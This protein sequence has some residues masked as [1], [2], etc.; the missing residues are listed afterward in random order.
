MQE[1]RGNMKRTGKVDS[2]NK[3]I[4]III[5]VGAIAIMIVNAG[6][7]AE[8]RSVK[9][10]LLLYI[11]A[12]L[13]AMLF[14]IVNDR[15]SGRVSKKKDDEAKSGRRI[16]LRSMF[17]L[18]PI[19]CFFIIYK[20]AGHPTRDILQAIPTLAGAA[21]LL[22]ITFFL[23]LFYSA[24]NNI[25]ASIVLTSLL[26]LGFG[27]INYALILF[28][29]E[30]LLANDIL[31]IRTALQVA[32]SYSFAF[33]KFSVIGI[34]LTAIWIAL[35]LGLKGY[36][37]IKGK[38]RF[39]PISICIILAVFMYGMVFATDYL[40][41]NGVKVSGWKPLKSYKANGYYIS[42]LI[43]I[44]QSSIT[45]PE[46]YTLE[47]VQEIA[48]RYSSDAADPVS[49]VSEQTP[50]IIAIMNESFADL[51]IMG[52]VE[53]DE[54]VLSFFNSL[55]D[56]TIR[57][58]MHSSVYGGHT[59]VSEFE[60]LTGDTE[61]FLPLN[62][63][64]YTSVLRNEE[65]SLAWE[66]K[67]RNYGGI[68]AFHP[69]YPDSYKRDRAYPLLGFSE[70]IASSDMTDPKRIRGFISDESDYE[71]L[72]SEF[73]EFRKTDESRPYFMFNVT[74][75]NHGGYTE[76]DGLV[77]PHQI[78]ITD[79]ELQEESAQQFLNLMKLSDQ[80][81]EK[82]IDYF[83]EI[84]EP[85][86]IVLY[87]DHQP[88]VGSDFYKVLNKRAG[89]LSELEEQEIKYRVPFI[90]WANYDIPER[91]GVE[92]SANYLA[93]YLLETIGAPMT[94]YQKF[95][96]DLYRQVPVVSE[97]CT[98]GN[99]GKIYSSEEATPYD[100]LLREYMI[101]QYNSLADNR[102]IASEFFYLK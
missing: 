54:E 30:P 3:I 8:T 77:K 38:R 21:N 25:K 95:L 96:M 49:E 24:S 89:N 9:I 94:G 97:I 32:N 75:Q 26:N 37:G 16:L 68:T 42:F 101:M 7:F 85:T 74:I 80:A 72:I 17:V 31:E 22:I 46:G 18:T 69:G 47:K 33:N 2:F 81:L 36:R 40:S 87:G 84:D 93:S 41:D 102:N 86:V 56:N 67:Q 88:K 90:I 44:K 83:S 23:F 52:E 92:I 50:N 61:R 45:K 55:T 71:R 20:I 64:P 14:V 51:E 53:T 58:T 98:I 27:L 1:N 99:D 66:L 70:H 34:V 48:D 13:A 4:A 15:L 43:T 57:G 78:D 76:E 19:I 10:S 39:I 79:T 63:I 28:R 12:S 100:D 6:A 35:A 73:E 91:T 11:A 60:F 29:S 59:A 65:P 5:L 82:L 62:S